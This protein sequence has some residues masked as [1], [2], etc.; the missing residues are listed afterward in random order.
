MD[1]LAGPDPGG[2]GNGP[3]SVDDEVSSP[4]T[5]EHKKTGVL[6]KCSSWEMLASG[7]YPSGSGP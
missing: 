2:T 6:K 4:P 1:G 7:L 5:V 3:G